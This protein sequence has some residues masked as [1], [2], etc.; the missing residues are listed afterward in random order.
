VPTQHWE[1]VGAVLAHLSALLWW[2]FLPCVGALAVWWWRR[3]TSPFVSDHAKEAFNFQLS[4]VVY[5]L[6]VSALGPVTC[7]VTWY[8]LGPML[9][10]FAHGAAFIAAWRAGKSEV[11]RYPITMRVL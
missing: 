1:R 10:V 3:A 5:A 9:A 8:V 11:Y 2:L 7:G 4:V 6:V